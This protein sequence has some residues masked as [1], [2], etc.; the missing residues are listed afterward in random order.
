[1]FLNCCQAC[2]EGASGEL[3][4]SRG[5]AKLSL[6]VSIRALNLFLLNHLKRFLP[7]VWYGDEAKTHSLQDLLNKL[8]DLIWSSTTRRNSPN[9]VSQLY[10]GVT[11]E[12]VMQFINPS[13][14]GISWK[15]AT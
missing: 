14:L 2:N 8:G 13:E 11:F 15:G 4:S 3:L 1:M 7:Y 6:H 9:H 10:I 5:I 12:P